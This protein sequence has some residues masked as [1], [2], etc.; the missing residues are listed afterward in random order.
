MY[1]AYL[2][3][4]LLFS[5]KEKKIVMLWTWYHTVLSVDAIDSSG[6]QQFGV[7]HNI[8]KQRI[9]LLGNFIQNAEQETINKS[10]N[11]TQVTVETT[12]AKPCSSCYGARE[13]CCQTC[14]EVRDAYRQKVN[15]FSILNL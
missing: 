14:A 3:M 8:F 7:E 13:G 9:N 12:E 11:Q 5:S 2:R 15:P 4:K 10:H 6:E 1:P